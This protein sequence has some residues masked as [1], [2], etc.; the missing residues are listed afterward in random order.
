MR[1]GIRKRMEAFSAFLSHYLIKD[2]YGRPGKPQPLPGHI[3]EQEQA[4][5]IENYERLLNDLTPD[6]AVYFWDAVHPEHQSK[7]A[8]GW[9]RKG[10]NTTIRRST[11]RR[12][13]TA[14]SAFGAI[15]TRL[16]I[17]RISTH[18]LWMWT[19][20]IASAPFNYLRNWK[21]ETLTKNAY[22]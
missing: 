20:L 1:D 13:A 17:W 12:R 6:E 21:P 22:I 5:F 14:G 16:L 8:H 15:F 10:A 3:D 18:P 9:M 4:E 11:G 2:R 7:P 19:G